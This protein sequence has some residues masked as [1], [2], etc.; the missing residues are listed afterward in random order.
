[1]SCKYRIMEKCKAKDNKDAFCFGK[2]NC[3]YYDDENTIKVTDVC[4][5]MYCGAE[6]NWGDSNN[7]FDA[8]LHDIPDK[9]SDNPSVCC[10]YCNAITSINRNFKRLIEQ[11]EKFNLW[12]NYM[13]EEINELEKDKDKVIKHYL[14]AKG[15][16]T[17]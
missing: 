15:Y 7:P 9:Y 10:G 4:K 6:I 8:G 12:I 2:D 17:F 14:E 5:C 13:K 16:M 3:P 1:M 11:P